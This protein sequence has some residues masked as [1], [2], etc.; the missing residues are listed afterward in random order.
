VTDQ[1][2][3]ELREQIAA[4]DRAFVETVNRRLELVRQLW[5][6]K[7]EQGVPLVDPA[8]EQELLRQLTEANPGPLSA[9]G[10]AELYAHVLELTK[11]EVGEAVKT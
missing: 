1:V 5:R 7:E 9:H 3:K 2:V 4:A 10:L 8:R 6:Y 11:R